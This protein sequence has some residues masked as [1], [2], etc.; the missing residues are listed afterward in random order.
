MDSI[1]PT[2]WR[3]VSGIGVGRRS[4]RRGPEDV[5]AVPV[6]QAEVHVHA[7]AVQVPEGLGHEGRGQA[8]LAGDAAHEA[9]EQDRVVAGGQRV[10]LVVQVHLE[11]AGAV[12]GDDGA[13]GHV[14]VPAAADSTWAKKPSRSCRSSRL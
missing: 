10:L 4:R 8:L 7:G 2:A 14:L 5:A 11:L 13:G 6:Q 12:L 9:P 3:S 1:P